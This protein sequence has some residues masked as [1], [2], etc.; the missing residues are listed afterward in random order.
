MSVF[1]IVLNL[2][3]LCTVLCSSLFLE[4]WASRLVERTVV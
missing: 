3:S 4:L 1:E 2:E